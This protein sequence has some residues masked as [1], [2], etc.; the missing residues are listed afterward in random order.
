VQ[1][2]ELS[3]ENRRQHIVIKVCTTF[4][5]SGFELYGRRL[6]ESWRLW[7]QDLDFVIYQEGFK[8]Q[9]GVEL[10]DIK[11]LVDFKHRNKGKPFQDFR[12][13]AVKFAHKTAAVIDAA[14][15]AD[16][17]IWVDG[18]VYTHKP[19]PDQD[20]AGWLPGKDEY[21]SWLWRDKMYPECGFYI[22]NLGHMQHD[23]I[24]A[25]WRRL[26]E[27]D[28]VYKLPEWH[29][30]FVLAHVIKQAGVKWRSLSGDYA[31]HSHPFVNG[32]LGAFMDHAKGPR[33]Q[34]G[35]SSRRDL[36]TARTEDYWI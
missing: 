17:L 2:Y 34:A 5:A 31:W 22:L 18:D 33:K 9:N 15:D 6:I 3:V 29:D 36:A 20:L 1:R 23:Q 7:P 8:V 28:D 10:L 30:S 35:R 26:Y 14:K 13:D 21:I 11:W 25:E 4:N 19:I 27:T 24:M 12:W 16:Y 32:P